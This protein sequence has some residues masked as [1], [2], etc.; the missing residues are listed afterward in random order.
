[1]A[2][3][4]SHPPD[5]ALA[6]SVALPAPGPDALGW[7]PLLAGLAVLRALRTSRYAVPA[8]L[9]WPNDVLVPDPE[10]HQDGP[11]DGW[12]KVCGVLAQVAG[13]VVVVGAG[14][15]IDQTRDQLPA[16][17]SPALSWRLARGGA[18]LPDGARQT[19]V[20]DYLSHL[21]GLLDL[22]RADPGAVHTAYREQ[23]GTLGRQ[24]R[25]ELPG[26]RAVDWPR[27]GRRGVR[28]PHGQGSAGAHRAPRR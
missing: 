18:V 8:A 26:G 3:S 12:G 10:D 17:T 28:R 11:G 21:A 6:I 14:L 9:K 13:P 2:G 7:V 1:M 27:H 22:L 5:T 24:V 20:G 19:W 16:A 4:G 23:C 15:N 25:V